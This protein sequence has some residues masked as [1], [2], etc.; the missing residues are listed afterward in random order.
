VFLCDCDSVY[1]SFFSQLVPKQYLM[2]QLIEMSMLART[3]LRRKGT[4]VSFWWH[5]SIVLS[6]LL[7]FIYANS[8]FLLGMLDGDVMEDIV[9]ELG[10]DEIMEESG[11]LFFFLQYLDKQ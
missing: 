8:L 7:I 11:K 5:I 6:C 2:F 10:E 3:K 1:R 4:K 9:D